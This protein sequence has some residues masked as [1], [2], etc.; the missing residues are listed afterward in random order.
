MKI[1][2]TLRQGKAGA[3]PV[4]GAAPLGVPTLHGSAMLANMH[5]CNIYFF[6]RA[7]LQRRVHLA[8]TG[9]S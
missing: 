2:F 1:S 5:W 9:V 3:K 4:L 8:K 7:F 6:R